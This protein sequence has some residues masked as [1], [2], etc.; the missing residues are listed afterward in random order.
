MRGHIAK[1]HG[2]Y[3]PVTYDKE[4]RK[5]KWHTGYSK[6]SDAEKELAKLVVSVH[7]GDYIEPSKMTVKEYLQYWLENH[8]KI[9]LARKTWQ[10]YEGCLKRRIYDE[11]GPIPLSKI[12]AL[13]IQQFINKVCS[14]AGYNLSNRTA[15]LDLAIIS[16]AFKQ[17]VYWGF[18]ASNPCAGVRQPRSTKSEMHI[19]TKEQIREVQSYLADNPDFLT[20]FQIALWSGARRGEILALK[21]QDVDFAGKR[22]M[23]RR[24]VDNANR[25]E[26][27]D[28]ET[29]SGRERSVPIAEEFKT[30]LEAWEKES[31]ARLL[32]LGEHL[33]SSHYVCL[34]KD[35]ERMMPNWASHSWGKTAKAIGAENVRFHDIR[36]TFASLMLEAGVHP[37]AVSDM[38]GHSSIDITMNIYSHI[39]PH[40][41]DDAAEKLAKIMS[42]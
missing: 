17:A 28:K 37:K 24:S 14:P 41:L 19:L 32:A 2:K 3:Y 23:I 38:L 22:L 4:T 18:I 13:H 30:I 29:K 25:S 26:I 21:W 31:K 16:G 33:K 15:R 7:A 1:K 34:R 9:A 6:E 10:E 39:M 27:E 12:K 40:I 36:H 8:A 11:I 35:G 42:K 20:V 5:Y